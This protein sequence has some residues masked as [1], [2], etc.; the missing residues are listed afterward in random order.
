MSNID[1]VPLEYSDMTDQEMIEAAEA[2]YRRMARR[3]TV[4]DYSTKAIPDGV[5]ESV[6]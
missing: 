3:R 5:L 2:F 4:R 1:S 6:W